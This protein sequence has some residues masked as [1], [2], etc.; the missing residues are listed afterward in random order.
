MDAVPNDLKHLRRWITWRLEEGQKRPNCR[1]QDD[2]NWKEFDSVEGFDRIGFVFTQDD[3]LCG[4]DLDDCASDGE[5]NDLANEVLSRFAGTAYAEVSPSG[6]GIKLWTIAKKPDWSKCT[7]GAGVECYDSNRW[8]A[9]TGQVLDGFGDIGNGQAA[10]DWLC[11]KYLKPEPKKQKAYEPV[12]FASTGIFDRARA[13]IDNAEKPMEGGRN[14]AAFRLAGHLM[15]LVQPD[16]EKLGF[17]D[18]LLLVKQ[19]NAS[20]PSPMDESEVEAVVTSASKSGTPREDKEASIPVVD[21][22]GIDLSGIMNQA[23]G[24]KAQEKADEEND[25]DEDFCRAMVPDSGLLRDVFEFYLDQAYRPSNVMG[26]SVATSLCQTIFGRRIRT[27]TDMR[28]NDYNLVLAPTGS[29][30]EAC[31]STITKI[32]LA[33]DPSGSHQIPP[34]VQSGNGLIRAIAMNP[35][36]IWVCDEFGKIM[37]A[38]L[39]KKGNHFIKSIGNHLLKI[40]SKSNGIYGGSA[41]ASEVKNRIIEPHLVILGLSTACTVFSS[42]SSDHVNDGLLGRI[43][44]WPVQE[45]PE[46]KEDM[47]I[48]EPSEQLVQRVRAWIEFAPGGNLGSQYPKPETIRMSDD[49]CARWKQHRNAIDECMRSEAESRS[50]IWTRVGAR[51]MKLALVHRAARLEVEPKACQWDFV[52][53][54]IQDINWGIKLSNW[55]A[56]IACDLVRENTVDTNTAK[57]KAILV[58][59]TANGPVSASVLLR[60]HRSITAGDFKAAAD[61]LGYTTSVAGKK[62]KGRPKVFYERP[63]K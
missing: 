54:E 34:D 53:I 1:W 61:S 50:A 6:T 35:C 17:Q 60:L 41:H 57:A 2:A 49:A 27:Q 13:Y 16:G 58:A 10:V 46:P 12:K 19:W 48:T 22:V 62:M 42:F 28:T 44:F 37:Q 55:L 8:F 26:L 33:A 18:V 52:Q 31:E 9:V 3:D 38:V 25:S 32:L 11:E 63:T 7:N 51:S 29:G 30:K 40:Y 45:R 56:R 20:C 5:L 43:S 47:E 23:W 59:A 14:N 36:G 24:T 15:A 21:T 4:I 39:D